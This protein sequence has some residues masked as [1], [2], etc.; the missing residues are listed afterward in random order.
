VPQYRSPRTM[1][2]VEAIPPSGRRELGGFGPPQAA[3]P[4]SPASAAR[5]LLRLTGGHY[6]RT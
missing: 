2:A 4:I 5:R 3:R 1:A 6:L